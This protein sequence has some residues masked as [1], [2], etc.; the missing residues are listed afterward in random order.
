MATLEDARRLALAL[1]ET[2]EKV[3]WGSAMWTVAGRGFVWERPLRKADVAALEALGQVV[4]DGE[5]LGVRVRPEDKEALLGSEPEV[6]FT[7]PHLDGYPAVL[8]RLE[9]IAPDELRELVVEAWLDRAP[10][11]LAAAYLAGRD[12]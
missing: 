9:R 12:G 3:S 1:P 10:K 11:R 5:V 7:V 6:F 8:V 2:G 4:P